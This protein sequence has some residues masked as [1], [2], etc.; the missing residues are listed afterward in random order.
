MLLVIDVFVEIYLVIRV[1][2]IE[3]FCP[4]DDTYLFL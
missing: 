3:K 2:T 4:L 1:I